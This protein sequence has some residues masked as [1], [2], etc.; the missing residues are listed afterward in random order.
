MNGLEEILL[1]IEQDGNARAEEIIKAAKLGAEEKKEHA[2]KEAELDAAKIISEAEK[3][4]E[5]ISESGKSGAEAYIKRA[6]LSAKSEIID[7]AVTYAQNEIINSDKYFDMLFMLIIK[8]AHN[9]QGI[10][11]LNERDK[12]NMPK[13]FL[14]KVNAALPEGG[15]LT[16]S[17]KT[18]DINGGC[19]IA[20]GGIEENCAVSELIAEK[21]DIIKDKLYQIIK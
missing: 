8:N 21:S 19:I 9:E 2:K 15:S 1:K 4:A 11:Q 17:E 7:S 20:Y 12:K 16:V 10:L 5:I 14:Q 6:V 13:D 18:S 3:K